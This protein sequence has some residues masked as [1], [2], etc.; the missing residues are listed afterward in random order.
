ML[1]VMARAALL[2]TAILATLAAARDEPIPA[3]NAPPAF[4]RSLSNIQNYTAIPAEYDSNGMPPEAA[5]VSAGIICS[6][7]NAS[8]GGCQL[9]AGGFL[10]L[11]KAYNVSGSLTTSRTNGTIT[12]TIDWTIYNVTGD[13]NPFFGTNIGAVEPRVLTVAVDTDDNQN[14]FTIGGNAP[15]NSTGS[16]GTSSAYA[17]FVPLYRCVSGEFSDCPADLGIGNGTY[18]QAC[19]P[20]TNEGLENIENVPVLVGTTAITYT[21]VTYAASL[22][23]NPHENLP[24]G[25]ALSGAQPGKSVSVRSALLMAALALIT[26]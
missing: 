9:S 16:N 2:S 25:L 22:T 17:T 1:S 11:P 7:N 24:K 20:E 21:N 18:L 13:Y 5:R 8:D 6:A 4:C 14:D 26:L 3:S 15:S 19:Y 23:N 10:E 12:R